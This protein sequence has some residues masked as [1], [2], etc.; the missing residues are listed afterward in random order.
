[1]PMTGR[2]VKKARLLAIVTAVVASTDL[3]AAQIAWSMLSPKGEGFS[4]EV[5]GP[6][7]PSSKPGY[8]V[9][10]AD[11]W[12][13]FVRVTTVSDAV[14]ES[15]GAT[16][17]G[18]IRQY[19]ESI[20]K[21]MVRDKT[22]RSRSDADFAGYPSL[23]FDADG[24]TEQKEAFQGKYWLLVTEEHHY[25]ILAIGP[26][27]AS[28]ADADRFLG[29]FRLLKA[30]APRGSGPSP[31]KSPLA[32]KL[33]APAL[34][35]AVLTVEE[36]LR[37]RIDELIQNA[38]PAQRLGNKWVP[39]LPAW[40]QARTAITKRLGRIGELYGTTGEMDRTF[41]A[42]VSR[43]APGPQADALVTALEGS[44]GA[45]ILAENAL[46]TFI[47]TVMAANP[48]APRAGERASMEQMNALAKAFDERLQSTLPR[49]RSREAEV[50][51]FM[52]TPTGDVLRRL[53]DSVLSKA[54]TDIT[55]ALNLMV[56][57]DRDAIMREIEAAVATVK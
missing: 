57:D 53:W 4:V 36:K 40:Q 23:R 31:A 21:G 32:E 1:M 28:S 17:R 34:A 26:K 29:S 49:D 39:A 47:S 30:A 38:P 9:Y 16:D 2:L 8:Y 15:V 24:E 56:F 35:A 13:F 48:N 19:L 46:I 37:E 44:L 6:A 52:S 42:A 11:P 50:G 43:L 33:T 25:T 41:D 55:G 10:N 54:T 20:H 3:R 5:P 12:A 51:R 18:P 22:E 14:R 27:G 7:N 45:A